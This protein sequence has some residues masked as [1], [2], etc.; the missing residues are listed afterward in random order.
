M[1]R[2]QESDAF[3]HDLQ[4]SAAQ[5]QPFLLGF[6]LLDLQDQVFFLQTV[7]IGDVQVFGPLPQCHQWGVFKFND[8]HI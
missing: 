8:S 3:A 2:A 6:G 4:D 7:G 5:L 1:T